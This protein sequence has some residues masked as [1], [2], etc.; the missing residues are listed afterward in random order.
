MNW[1]RTL[2]A[3]LAAALFVLL[4]V[5]AV[6]YIGI[7]VW[8]TRLYLLDAHYRLHKNLAQSF[9][10]E[11]LIGE[12]GEVRESQ[13]KEIFHTLMLVN[14]SIEVY[15][16]DTTGN[17]LSY[18]AP[19]GRVKARRIDVQAVRRFL[20]GVE[21]MPIWGTDPRHPQKKALF[22][23]A[24]VLSGE[25]LR[26][27]LY[28]ILE[29]E[30]Y[31]GALQM[32]R[33]S[34][35]TRLVV[36]STVGALCAVFL[37][38]LLSF[39][40]ITR[41]LHRLSES[42]DAFR[43]QDAVSYSTASGDEL[44]R[45]SHSFERMRE[46]ITQQVDRIHRSDAERRRMIENISHDL[47]TPLSSMQG[48]LETLLLKHGE[49]G[50]EQ[51]RHYLEVAV[52]NS[53]RLSRLVDDLFEF[54]HLDAPELK[55]HRESFNLPELV[56]D[57]AQKLSGVIEAKRIELNIIPPVEAA[58]VQADLALVERVLENILKNAVDHLPEEGVVTIS[59][60]RVSHGMLETRISDTGT[61][62]PQEDLGRIF[63]RFYR[64]SSTPGRRRDGHGLGLAIVKRIVEL[65]GGTVEGTNA[66]EGGAVFRF[67]LPTQRQT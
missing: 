36:A 7:T 5:G 34:H 17:L 23:V 52:A 63:D 29:G 50:D 11:G 51:R 6:A 10:A 13:L 47:R 2:Y 55:L 8:S 67:T 12:R 31:H 43:E 25:Q 39:F 48:H 45:L 15:L 37:L 60:Q 14:P 61:G 27:Y 9:V 66:A 21:A 44:E 24:P 22:S 62:I 64:G 41:R 35:V 65:H 3:K 4:L 1:F 28:V 18:S 59:F 16:T 49:V 54:A 46:R 32:F 30:A 56:Q 53:R 42:V 26:G 38:G 40:L 20:D 33:T 19:A 58:F 57:V